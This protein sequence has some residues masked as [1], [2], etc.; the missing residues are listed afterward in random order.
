MIIHMPM[1]EIIELGF[2]SDIF[3]AHAPS[4]NYHMGTDLL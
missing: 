1:G 2:R 4:H 3:I